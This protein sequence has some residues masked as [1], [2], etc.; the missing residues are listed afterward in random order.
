M[1]CKG[2]LLNFI[3]IDVALWSMNLG[4]DV[5]LILFTFQSGE[6][7]TMTHEHTKQVNDIQLSKD[8]TCLISASKDTTAKVI[9]AFSVLFFIFN[10]WNYFSI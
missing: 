9:L 7:L 2:R 6:K 10:Y 3:G 8:M 5:N 4:I 1:G